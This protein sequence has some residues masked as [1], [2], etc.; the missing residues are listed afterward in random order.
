MPGTQYATALEGVR[1]DKVWLD[2]PFLILIVVLETLS[3]SHKNFSLAQIKSFF[4][5]FLSSAA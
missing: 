5:D 2:K 3:A 1:V 4:A